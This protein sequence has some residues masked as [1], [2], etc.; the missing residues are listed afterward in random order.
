[1]V[2]RHPL[3]QF[4]PW[5]KILAWM[6]P[7]LLLSLVFIPLYFSQ[8]EKH[9]ALQTE[10]IQRRSDLSQ[11][12]QLEHI[13]SKL[14][15]GSRLQKSLLDSTQSWIIKKTTAAAAADSLRRIIS[16]QGMNIS[17]LQNQPL[18]TKGNLHEY[19]VSFVGQSKS[20]TFSQTLGV[21]YKFYPWFRVK[22]FFLREGNGTLNYRLTCSFSIQVLP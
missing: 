4:I 17:Q 21:L 9:Q 12:H 19:E 10:L 15:V 14:L 2:N 8:F 20:Q 6:L 22:S 11:K 18:F 13:Q 1:M 3:T 16:T 7:S 5:Y